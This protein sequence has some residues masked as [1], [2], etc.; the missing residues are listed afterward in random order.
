MVKFARL[1]HT[2]NDPSGRAWKSYVGRRGYRE[3]AWGVLLAFC[4]GAFPL[5]SYLK[6]RLEPEKHSE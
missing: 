6:A 1:S 2:G 4:T 3:G 5:L